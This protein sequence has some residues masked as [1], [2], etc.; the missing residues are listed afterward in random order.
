MSD[1]RKQIEE[2]IKSYREKLSKTQLC[3]Y[4]VGVL[5]VVILNL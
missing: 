2:D 3:G 1:F 4:A 5:S